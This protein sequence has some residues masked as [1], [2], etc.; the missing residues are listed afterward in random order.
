[1]KQYNLTKEDVFDPA[2]SNMAT[3]VALMETQ[4][5]QDTKKFLKEQGIDLEM[6]DNKDPTKVKRSNTI[7]IV[8]NLPHDTNEA[9]LKSMFAKH[10]DLGK[11][12]F[13]IPHV[14]KT[15]TDRCYLVCSP[16]FKDDGSSGVSYPH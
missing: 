11:V 6:M 8:K 4:I 2:H 16:A 12:C 14:C 5:I 7:I 1:V 3:S 9:L 13:S 10:G 15:T